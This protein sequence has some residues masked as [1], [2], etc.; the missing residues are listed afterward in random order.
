MCDLKAPESVPGDILE[1]LTIS[2]PLSHPRTH[3]KPSDL[4][5]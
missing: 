5:R 2:E 1:P 3:I 4:P